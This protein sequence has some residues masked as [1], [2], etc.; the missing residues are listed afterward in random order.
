MFLFGM[1]CTVCVYNGFP[2][3]YNAT[4]QTFALC[5][6]A[7]AAIVVSGGLCL[8][9]SR[10]HSRLLAKRDSWSTILAALCVILTCETPYREYFG[11]AAMP[12]ALKAVLDY[13]SGALIPSALVCR[14]VGLYAKH[15][16]QQVALQPAVANASSA[17]SIA[18][19]ASTTSNVT[20]SPNGPFTAAPGGSSDL[21]SEPQS[22]LRTSSKSWNHTIDLVLR[23]LRL[24]TP[25]QLRRV[26]YW[27]LLPW[28]IYWEDRRW[29]DPG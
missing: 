1:A 18:S 3:S 23:R 12:C 9:W 8:A 25:A 21:R 6:F 10:R 29:Y 2:V 4:R 16:H 20:P 17:M 24:D 7:F 5:M 11:E 13:L 22:P 26:V 14:C 15:L 28:V 27:W 19:D